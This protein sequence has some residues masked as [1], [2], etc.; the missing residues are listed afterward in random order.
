MTERYMAQALSNWP[1]GWYVYENGNISGPYS[2]ADAFSLDAETHE[3][4][5]RLVSRKGFTQWY[6]LHDL[7]EIFKLTEQIGQKAVLSE[8]DMQA[9]L[10]SIA[11]DDEARAPSIATPKAE[12]SSVVPVVS[13]LLSTAS[14]P[15]PPQK[16]VDRG[17]KGQKVASLAAPVSQTAARPL[18]SKDS[19]A[20][21]VLQAP[22]ILPEANPTIR[23]ASEASAA[24]G[25]PVATRSS[26]QKSLARNA[27]LQEFFLQRGRLRLG[28][29]RNPWLS[30]FVGLPLSLGFYW[31]AWFG[32]LARE[33]AWHA[34]GLPRSPL[35]PAVLA[36]IPGLH[37]YMTYRLAQ[38]ICEAEV[39]NK[40][41]SISPGLAALFSLCPPLA[42][43]YLQDA[44]NRH[45]LM[46][47]RHALAKKRAAI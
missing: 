25:K 36:L 34:R 17:V 3:G 16:R 14:V 23:L 29:L 31:A 44:A 6:A 47:V 41:R 18:L 1:G 32:E 38:L 12:F 21:P 9:K 15:P 33:M 19:A 43:A 42:M 5:P 39:Q 27:V 26:R 4:K 40:Y 22:S 35:K 46:H 24:N 13:D 11:S 28:K 20:A 30:S 37:V 45:W 10:A 2:A 7:S 8:A